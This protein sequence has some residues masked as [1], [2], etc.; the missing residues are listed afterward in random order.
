M[1]WYAGKIRQVC[2]MLM[3][4]LCITLAGGTLQQAGTLQKNVSIICEDETICAE[5]VETMRESERQRAD[6]ITFVAWREYGT[7]L[8]TDA[9]ELRNATA[10]VLELSG[11]SELLIPYGATLQEGDETGC[12][13]G[14]GLAEALYGSHEVSGNTL[15][16]DGKIFIVR[17]V[18]K[19]PRN[20]L[21]VENGSTDAEF[22]RLTL[23]RT[24]GKTKG[25]TAERFIESYGLAAE[26]LR[27]DI[28]EPAYLLELV[29]GKW[30][31][32]LQ[33]QKNLAKIKADAAHLVTIEQSSLEVLWLKNIGMAA[34]ELF[35]GLALFA[36]LRYAKN[37]ST[38]QKEAQ[39]G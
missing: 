38:R 37:T 35:A 26:Q 39:N 18:L 19:E 22:D 21:V 10:D 34:A 6:G 31:N 2:L 3:G 1:R 5:E 4:C 13:L 17:G 7:C 8:V 30:S 15:Y 12:L 24:N 9:D 27:Y 28:L 16:Y 29:P 23:A 14:Q 32:F 20:L 25:R 33:L 36:Q 11:S